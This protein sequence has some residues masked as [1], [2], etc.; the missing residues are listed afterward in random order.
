MHEVGPYGRVAH[1]NPYVNKINRRKRLEYAKNYREKPLDFWN[2]L[3]WS[4]DSKFNLFGSDRKVMV[5]RSDKEEFGSECIIPTIKY[6]GGNDKCWS[7]FSSSGVSSLIFTDG[8][9]TGESYREILENNSLK[10]V[11][12]LGMNHDWIFQHDNDPKHRPAIVAN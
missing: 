8:N 9:M 12:K 6:G 4:D 10:S 7:C 3:V 11:E 1:K 5:W 2:K